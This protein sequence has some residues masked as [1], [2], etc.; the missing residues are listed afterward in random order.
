MKPVHTSLRV[1]PIYCHSGAAGASRRR[2]APFQVLVFFVLALLLQGCGGSKPP[3]TSYASVELKQWGQFPSE[4]ELPEYRISYGDLLEVKFFNNPEFNETVRVR[5]DG[6]IT[7]QRVGEMFV[8]GKTPSQVTRE[9]VETYRQ[10][11]VAPEVT[12]FVREFGALNVYVLGMVERPGGVLYNKNLDIL[13]AIA[14]AGGV[15]EGAKTKSIILLRRTDDGR[16][17]AWSFDLSFGNLGRTIRHN[18]A[19]QPNDI[20][21]VPKTAFASAT[22]FMRRLFEGL[23]PP[24]DLYL[25]TIFFYTR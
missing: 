14:L 11:L 15:K 4:Q 22:D 25:R 13:Q 23:L 24:V 3:L 16:L 18:V 1:L 7:L 9:V 5:P 19:I 2:S 20:I 6:R 17:H 21:Y 12:V 8:V 10:I